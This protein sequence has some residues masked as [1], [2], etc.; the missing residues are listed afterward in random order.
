MCKIVAFLQF[1]LQEAGVRP[2]MFVCQNLL[3]NCFLNFAYKTLI[4]DKMKQFR[5]LPDRKFIARMEESLETA[6]RI[7]SE[8][9]VLFQTKILW[10]SF[11]LN[12]LLFIFLLCR[13]INLD[14]NSTRTQRASR[15]HIC[16]FALTLNLGCEQCLLLKH[17][18]VLQNFKK[19]SVAQ[20]N[21][22]CFLKFL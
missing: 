16:V 1:L 12:L 10:P 3:T 18:V 22:M 21:C 8:Q 14:W 4:C 15:N 7:I 20:V 11:I 19:L 5:F 9:V 2:N 6:E 13:N 17:E